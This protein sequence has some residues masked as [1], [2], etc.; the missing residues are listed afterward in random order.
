MLK[1]IK[2]KRRQHATS[3]KYFYHREGNLKNESNGNVRN[4]N[5][6]TQ[7][8]CTRLKIKNIFDRIIRG[9]DIMEK[10]IRDMK[11]RSTEITQTG[12]M[13]KKGKKTT[14]SRYVYQTV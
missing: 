13:K 2:Q 3:E 4:K 7:R 14:H 10:N 8:N 6:H 9:F 12:K 1:A 5:K 11:V